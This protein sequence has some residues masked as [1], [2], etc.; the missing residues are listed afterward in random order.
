M[1]RVERILGDAIFNSC[2]RTD[3]SSNHTY[4]KAH[5]RIELA[6][7]EPPQYTSNPVSGSPKKYHM[8]LECH[9][10]YTSLSTHGAPSGHIEKFA[11]FTAISHAAP[12]P[13]Y[14]VQVIWPLAQSDAALPRCQC[15]S[16]Q[17]LDCGVRLQLPKV[18]SAKCW[19]AFGM[20]ET[21]P[22]L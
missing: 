8:Q 3:A 13:P 17:R 21:I 9:L 16:P 22:S 11:L 18:G 4:H 2:H 7:S 10:K 1:A 19:L 6:K 20:E 14:F 12:A 5:L 15:A